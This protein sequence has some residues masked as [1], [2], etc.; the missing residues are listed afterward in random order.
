MHQTP[1]I[2]ILISSVFWADLET[3]EG[4]CSN[5]FYMEGV[6]LLELLHPEVRI[7]RKY[8]IVTYAEQ[9]RFSHSSEM[10]HQF[11]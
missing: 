8:G 9:S 7:L 2:V 5:T 11:V 10:M 4:V 6:E 1:N 3:G